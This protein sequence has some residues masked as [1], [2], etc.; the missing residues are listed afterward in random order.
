VLAEQLADLTISGRKRKVSDIDLRHAI[1]LLI[2][3]CR[4]GRL[5]SRRRFPKHYQ[6]ECKP[7]ID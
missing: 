1:K 3:K 6:Q 4:N 2:R 7:K 5:M